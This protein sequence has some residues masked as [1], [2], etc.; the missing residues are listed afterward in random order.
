MEIK[1][2]AGIGFD[3]IFR[4][5]NQAFA[6]YEVQPDKEELLT[7]VQRRGFDPNLSFAAF[8][9]NKIVSF[10]CNGIGTFE[11]K[12]TAYDTGTGTI[13]DYRGQGLATKVFDNS[14]P[15]LREAGIGQYLLEVLQHNTGAVS[16]Y[17]KIGFEVTREFYYFRTKAGKVK[18]EVKAVSDYLI[19]EINIEKYPSIS[20]FG[21]FYPSWQNSFESIQ[22][23][24]E[25]FVTLGV[26]SGEKP[27]GYC[28]FEPVAGDVTQIGVDKEYRRKGIGSL[29]LKE[30]LRLNKN[31]SI[32]FINTD[33]RC[34]S[35][36]A[37][38][39]SKNI[40]PTGKQFEM[41]K[42]I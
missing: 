7:M 16:L 21:D 26:F 22:R 12:R 3:T 1:S 31:D 39:K 33:I 30:M 32:K 13:K 20:S 40:E 42:T 36:N 8:E 11:S 27:V 25:K 23:S 5:F 29:L 4:A 10:T 41:V 18:N 6:D 19:R 35:I 24:P 17:R 9:G 34:T 15:Y 14:L 28:V 37:F 2:L 38:L